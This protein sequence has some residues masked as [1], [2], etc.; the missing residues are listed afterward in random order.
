[1][2]SFVEIGPPVL[3]E[4]NFEGFLPY[5]GLEA[6]LVT[7]PGLLI[8]ALVTLPKGAAY[9]KLALIGEAVSEE[10]LFEDEP[11]GSFF[12]FFFFFFRMIDI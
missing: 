10:N 4:K 5:I 3:E 11:L 9:K 8:Y 7:W 1:M 12:F 6:I 2:P